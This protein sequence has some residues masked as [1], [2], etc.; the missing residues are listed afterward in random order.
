MVR[1]RPN[2]R[3]VLVRTI[4]PK[5]AMASTDSLIPLEERTVDFYGDSILGLRVAGEPQLDIYLPIRPLYEYLGLAWSGPYER[6]KRTQC[7]MR[8]SSS[9]V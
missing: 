5:E 9:F 8:Y 3:A 7:S 1:T 4:T 2:S 6:L